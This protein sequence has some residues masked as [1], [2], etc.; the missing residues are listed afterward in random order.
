AVPQPVSAARNPGGKD[1]KVAH[2]SQRRFSSRSSSASHEPTQARNNMTT[3][4]PTMMRNAKN[5]ITTGGQFSG[6]ILSSPTSP[7]LRLSE[8]MRLP[9]GAGSVIAKR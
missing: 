3:P 4:Q 8:S 7:A 5:G 1:K 2:K 9:K 6:G